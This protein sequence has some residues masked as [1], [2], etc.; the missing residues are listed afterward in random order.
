M[1]DVKFIREN[2]EKVKKTC[3]AKKV[4]VDIDRLL[5]LDKRR[6]EIIQATEAI[7]SEKNKASKTIGDKNTPAGEKQKIIFEMKE[8]DKKS[9]ILNTEL[10][11]IEDN[12]YGLMLQVPNIFSDDVPLGKDES[13]NKVLRK[14]GDI[15]KFDFKPKDHLEL[16]QNLG[17][18]NTEKAAKITGAR[19]DYLMGKAALVQFSL[20]KYVFDIL[21]DQK[22][23]KKIADSV[24]KG[25]CPKTFIPVVPPV[26][27]KPDVFR[28]MARLSEEDKEERYYFPKDDLYL[29]GSAEHTLGPL[30][31]DEILEEK[32][33]PLRY[34]G[35][36]TCFRRE[37]G[38]YGKDTKG[39]LRVHQFDKIE[40]E[41]FTVAENSSAEQEFFVAIQEYIVQSLGIPY[42]VILI[43][44]GDMGRPDARQFDIECWMPGQN[45]Y[46]ETHTSDLMTDYQARRLNTRV[47]RNGNKIEYVHMNDATA[48]AMGRILIAIIENYQ[49]KDGSV[50]VPKVLKKY[51]G[52][53][54][55]K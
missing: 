36:S 35:Y 44:T 16:G 2:P 24:K 49:Q 34:V 52:F 5:T 17:I 9:D 43:C 45:K 38:S 11:V 7:S 55:I 20:I 25:Y 40:M 15:P 46:R 32:N 13:E 29:V 51:T 8:I 41:A 42:Q 30:H 48:L 1:L 31:M 3:E 37:A 33:L 6:R 22:I 47:K 4:N 23:I 14:V 26:M 50:K 53:D 12:F 54:V 27:I 28:R 39:I 10:K 21:T 18:I 19:F